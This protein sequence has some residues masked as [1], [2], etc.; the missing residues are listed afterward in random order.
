[1][2]LKA[3]GNKHY[4][5]MTLIR[6]YAIELQESPLKKFLTQL[7]VLLEDL[8]VEEIVKTYALAQSMFL[9]EEKKCIAITSAHKMKLIVFVII[10][11]IVYFVSAIFH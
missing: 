2:F 6:S 5:D 7:F 11:V 10:T 3:L 1:M 9:N 8:R 4:S